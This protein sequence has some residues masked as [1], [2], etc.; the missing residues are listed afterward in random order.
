MRSLIPWRDG[1]SVMEEMRKEMEGL[2]DRFLAPMP[3]MG[4]SSMLETK[5]W[6]PSIDIEET[7][8][9]FVVKADVPGVEPKDLDVS[10]KDNVLVLRGE[11]KEEKEKKEKN[12]HRVERF[13]GS[14]FRA[15][16]MPAETDMEK[17]SAT[18]AK[19]VV[20]I[21]IPKKPGVEA[22]RIPVE[23]AK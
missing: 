8:K 1:S 4:E 11:K 21:T 14:F 16:P 18:S 6:S 10:V 9:A 13:S 15:I 2:F 22:K 5:T 19:G 7:D 20:T 23:S 17:I 3:R 12:F